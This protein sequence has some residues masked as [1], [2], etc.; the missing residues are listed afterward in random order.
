MHFGVHFNANRKIA[1][2]KG[3]E[4]YASTVSVTFKVMNISGI[5]PCFPAVP[6][7]GGT[8]ALHLAAKNN[9]L[10]CAKE[11]ILNGADY[12]AVDELGRTSLYIAAELGLE[13]MV[14]THLRNAV[15]RDILSL[16]VRNT[17]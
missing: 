1:K 16:P 13:E 5:P 15:G 12:N 17:S 9:H 11:L 3:R 2:F 6:H 7:V 4:I 8:L 14:L 10:L